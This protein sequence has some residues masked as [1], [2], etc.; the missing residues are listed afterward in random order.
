MGELE[1]V[2]RQ[3]GPEAARAALR[4]AAPTPAAALVDKTVEVLAWESW[5]ESAEKLKNAWPFVERGGVCLTT[6][7]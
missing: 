6:V 7:P 1:R 2:R 3:V 5:E 4:T